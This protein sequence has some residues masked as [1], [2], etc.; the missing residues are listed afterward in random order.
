MFLKI[1]NKLKFV[2]LI[3]NVFFRRRPHEFMD[4]PKLFEDGI[5]YFDI[6]QG[7]IENCWF[8]SAWAALALRPSLVQKLFITQEYNEEGIYRLRLLKNGEWHWV[9]ID[10]YIPCYYNGRPM[11]TRGNGMELWVILLEKAF[12]KLHGNYHWLEYGHAYEAMIDLTGCPVICIS[13]RENDQFDIDSEEGKDKLWNK[14]EKYN[15]QGFLISAHT[16]KSDADSINECW[17]K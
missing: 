8:L 14:I 13:L 15:Q 16:P 4:E 12:A 7:D 9:T 1:S 5:E 3:W 2:N 17:S 6:L 10:D 11:F